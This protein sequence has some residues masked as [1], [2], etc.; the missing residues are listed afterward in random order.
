MANTQDVK[1]KIINYCKF[2]VVL[3]APNPVSVT[4]LYDVLVDKRLGVSNYLNGKRQLSK[5]L[6]EK[7]YG[8][9]QFK[10]VVKRNQVLWMCAK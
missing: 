8:S 6:T 1:S 4:E 7:W 5:M 3:N 9:P 10:R 2:Y